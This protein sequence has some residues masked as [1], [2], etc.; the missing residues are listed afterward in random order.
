VKGGVDRERTVLAPAA[1][2]VPVARANDDL[3]RSSTDAANSGRVKGA[4]VTKDVILPSSSQSSQT[5]KVRKRRNMRRV[6]IVTALSML[7]MAFSVSVALASQTTTINPANAPSGTHL[8]TGTIT[9][10]VDPSTLAVTC[11]TY[12]LAGVGHTN[13]TV[14]LVANYTATV[15]CFNPG[16]PS[17]K[18]NP[19]E[20]HT[21]SF[22]AESTITVSSTKNGRLTIPSRSVN[23]A[24]VGQVCPNPNWT[25]VIRPGTLTLVSFT[26]TVT[27]E[28]FT[29]AYITISG[30]DP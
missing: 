8:Q 5:G 6:G 24:S 21:T 2:K 18:N 27:F 11:S 23:P 16:D 28:G 1:L 9:C 22:S 17:N 14:S 30:N 25:P 4:E 12:E 3:L 7:L 15:D 10:T 20:S 13:A 26:Y 29:G 19:I